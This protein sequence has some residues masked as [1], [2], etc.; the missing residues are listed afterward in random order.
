MTKE[1]GTL[2]ELNVK[3]GDVVECVGW[4]DGDTQ[5]VGCHYTI[6]QGHPDGF[7]SGLVAYSQDDGYFDVD[8]E[9][10]YFRIISSAP[11]TDSIKMEEI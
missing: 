3:R 11:D 6:L 7:S 10:V 4:Y 8:D 2:K 1:T 5:W 9:G